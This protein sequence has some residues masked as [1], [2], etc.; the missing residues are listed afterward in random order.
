MYRMGQGFSMAAEDAAIMS[1]LL[2][3][4]QSREEIADAFRAFDKLRR[5]PDNRPGFVVKNGAQVAS[6]CAGQRGLDPSTA[7]QGLDDMPGLFAHLWHVDMK[8]EIRTA[9]GLFDELKS[10]S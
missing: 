1:A 6:I 4:V 8:A 5:G 2:G 7:T 9:L 10:R 3:A